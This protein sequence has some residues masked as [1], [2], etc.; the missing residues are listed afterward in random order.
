MQGG[1]AVLITG[2]KVRV[3][4]EWQLHHFHLIIDG[5]LAQRRHVSH[6]PRV[7]VSPFGEKQ[8]GH[9]EIAPSRRDEKR[10]SLAGLTGIDLRALFQEQR[11]DVG[12]TVA[13]GRMRGADSRR[14]L[15][16]LD[17]RAFV[18]YE[19]RQLRIAIERG[20]MERSPEVPLFIDIGAC[21]EQGFDRVSFA[22]EDGVLQLARLPRCLK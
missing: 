19:L 5:R 11:D 17:V 20:D 2:L 16:G 10:R 3:I 8:L 4:V 21:S 22:G 6:V 9:V 1:F 7:H 13:G 15:L 14:L 18:D 12:M